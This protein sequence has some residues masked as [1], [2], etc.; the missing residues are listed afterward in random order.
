MVGTNPLAQT[1]MPESVTSVPS[2]QR[3][4]LLVITTNGYCE[5]AQWQFVKL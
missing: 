3:V 1:F 4:K 5:E 2:T